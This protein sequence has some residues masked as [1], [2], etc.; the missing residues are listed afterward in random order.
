MVNLI[1]HLSNH[2]CG[3]Y[4]ASLVWAPLPEG[5][6]GFTSAPL[7]R[8]CPCWKAPMRCLL[9][10]GHLRRNQKGMSNIFEGQRG[11]VQGC[12]AC[13]P[14]LASAFPPAPTSGGGASTSGTASAQQQSSFTDT[15]GRFQCSM[16]GQQ[17]CIPAERNRRKLCLCQSQ[18][19]AVIVWHL[20]MIRELLR[21]QWTFK[22]ERW[23]HARASPTS[24]LHC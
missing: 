4:L 1:G 19:P 7:Q 15:S 23:V 11:I 10:P 6:P 13:A 17:W 12:R 5:M 14:C 9:P 18:P 22:S 20:H 2:P 3:Q 8:E 16:T 24:S 21:S